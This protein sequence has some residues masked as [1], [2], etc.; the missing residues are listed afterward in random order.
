M[1]NEKKKSYLPI[2]FFLLFLIIIL[3][4]A[5]STI[6][7]L[8]NSSNIKILGG[9]HI[10]NILIEGL[11]QQEAINL[12]ND[13]IKEDQKQ[14]RIVIINGEVYKI[15][16][17]QIEVQYDL[18]EAIQKAYQIG[19][20]GN[21]FENNFEILNT[22]FSKTNIDI[23]MSYNQELLNQIVEDINAKLP[24]AMK[25]NTYCI[26]NEELIITRGKEG[27]VL[28]KEEMKLAI[29][30]SIKGEKKEPVKVE[31]ILEKCPEIDIEKI[32][33]E[34]VS[35]PKNAIFD[36]ENLKIIPHENGLEFS[37]EEA[38][39]ILKEEKEEYVIKL[40]VK[41]PEILTN[42]MGEEA[43][44]HVLSNFST[45]YDETN[46]SR[47]KNLKLATEKINGTVVMPGEVFSYNETV[48]K[49]TVQAGYEYANGF[50]GGKVVKMIG[51]GICQV[52]STL[53]NTVLYANL[54]IIER[55][56]HMFKTDY[57]EPGKDATVVYGSLDFKFK[58]T[59]TNPIMIKAS[60]S[61]GLLEI[62]IIGIKEKI[63]YE[64][65]LIT[66]VI[67]YI[68]FDVK[69]E[70]DYTLKSGEEKLMQGGIQGCKSITYRILKM[71]GQEKSKEV[72]STDT[73][74]KL[75]KII[76]RGPITQE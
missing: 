15:T 35:E 46:Y 76:K 6:F 54:D 5:L 26:E 25:D 20:D 23:E 40:I 32:Y 13:K 10:K 51:G 2:M 17:E 4:F 73:Y 9:I 72:L 70:D 7:A 30:E 27:F 38:K 36:E 52:S 8:L 11:T 1:K 66:N 50:A 55:Y 57:V 48:G 16:P 45:K 49:R 71:N 59:R 62:K 75:N 60:A 12:L 21:I 58:N 37:L 29:I 74:E 39:E 3:L 65:E 31:P 19:R 63:E 56:N 34:V 68:P 44:P 14:E 61:G 22:F 53:Y 18:E 43:F 33:T 42:E 24:N 47:T 28:N 69:Y 41:E 67:E 64:V